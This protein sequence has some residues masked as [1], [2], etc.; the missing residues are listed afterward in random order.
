[1]FGNKIYFSLLFVHLEV[2]TQKDL[3]LE[4][5]AE[6]DHHLYDCISSE[7]SVGGSHTL[8]HGDIKQWYIPH[9]LHPRSVCHAVITI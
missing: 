8:L 3:V 7:L 5:P 4:H 2:R 1:M 9:S 6:T